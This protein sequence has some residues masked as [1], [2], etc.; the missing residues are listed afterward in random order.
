MGSAA[1]RN[2]EKT[3]CMQNKPS[4]RMSPSAWSPGDTSNIGIIAMG[5]STK[6]ETMNQRLRP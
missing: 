4:P 1:N 3:K 5:A 2:A 6:D